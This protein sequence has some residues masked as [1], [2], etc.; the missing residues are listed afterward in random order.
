MFTPIKTYGYNFSGYSDNIENIRDFG[1][2]HELNESVTEK[3]LNNVSMNYYFDVNIRLY[4][5]NT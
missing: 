2:A 3:V 4:L 1:N 5:W